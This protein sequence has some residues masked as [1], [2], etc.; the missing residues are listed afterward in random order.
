[1]SKVPQ[2]FICSKGRAGKTTTDALLEEIPVEYAF[3]VEPDEVEAYTRHLRPHG[4]VISL[5]EGDRGL[6]YSR[7]RTKEI[8]TA[9]HDCF[10]VLDDDISSF[11]EVRG[12]KTRKCSPAVLLTALE[13]FRGSGLAMVSF[14][15]QQYA[16]S[17]KKS[18]SLGKACD[19]C[20]FFNSGR[21]RDV[22]FDER[23]RLK[24]DREF[25]I[26]L[27][28]R[29]ERFGRMNRYAISVPSLGTND[30]GLHDLYK[31]KEDEKYAYLLFR[32]YGPDVC[33][34]IRKKDGRLDV[35]IDFNKFYE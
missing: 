3:V 29:G 10:A 22:H 9:V 27:A 14:E 15:Y 32:K 1:M 18:V 6:P 21:T 17:Q 35:R 5:P 2:F 16:W 33:K 31:A 11:A 7:E 4:S 28:M 23:F 19:C 25:C 30:G 13:W 34:L 20:V 12:G 26:Q 24:G 8:A